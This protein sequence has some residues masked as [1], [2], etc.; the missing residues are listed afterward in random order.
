[1]GQGKTW[2][3]IEWR[4]IKEDGF[5][6]FLAQEIHYYQQLLLLLLPQGLLE[7]A[8][9]IVMPELFL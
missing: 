9:E 2:V 6:V 4:Q 5:L 1:M 7:T 8:I 3:E